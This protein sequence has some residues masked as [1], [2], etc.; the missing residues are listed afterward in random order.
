MRSPSPDE[1]TVVAVCRSRGGQWR[2]TSSVADAGAVQAV[3]VEAGRRR[4]GTGT[5]VPGTG[6]AGWIDGGRRWGR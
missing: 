5:T 1:E 6:R 4:P 3:D 2:P